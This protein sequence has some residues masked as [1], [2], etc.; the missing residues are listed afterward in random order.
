[1]FDDKGFDVTSAFGIVVTTAGGTIAF[2]TNVALPSV[3]II[4]LNIPDNPTFTTFFG[5]TTKIRGDMMGKTI[6]ILKLFPTPFTMFKEI[7]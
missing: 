6:L 3:P 1:M 5:G 7:F 4:I 2:R